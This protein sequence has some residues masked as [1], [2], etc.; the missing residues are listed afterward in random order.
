MARGGG[1]VFARKRSRV[2]RARDAV[3]AAAGRGERE[4]HALVRARI[5]NGRVS[6]YAIN[7]AIMPAAMETISQARQAGHLEGR[8]R[9]AERTNDDDIR[10]PLNMARSEKIYCVTE[11]ERE[12]V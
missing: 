3:V 6:A 9:S 5:Q 8:Q 11:R 2:E 10:P 7:H 1:V 4:T 12:R